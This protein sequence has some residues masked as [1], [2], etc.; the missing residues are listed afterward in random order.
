[1]APLGEAYIH[2]GVFRGQPAMAPLGA[3]NLHI[4]ASWNINIYISVNKKA[5]ISKEFR[6]QIT[7]PFLISPNTPLYAFVFTKI[8]NLTHS[9]ERKRVTQIGLLTV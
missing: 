4:F 8:S 5:S 1:M 7:C 9:K 6:P 2:S 3:E